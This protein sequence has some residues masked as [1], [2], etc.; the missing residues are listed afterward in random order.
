MQKKDENEII[1]NCGGDI[2][3]DNNRK[4]KYYE[5]NLWPRWVFTEKVSDFLKKDFFIPFYPYKKVNKIQY[6]NNYLFF[7]HMDPKNCFKKIQS[8][9]DQADI[10]CFNMEFP[11]SD[12]PVFYDCIWCK[13]EILKILKWA[14]I[15]FVNIANNHIFDLWLKWFKDTMENLNY[16][17]ISFFWGNNNRDLSHS[18][19][20]FEKDWTKIW[21]L[22]YFQNTRYNINLMCST[23]NKPWINPICEDEIIEDIKNAKNKSWCDLVFVSLHWDIENH[24]RVHKKFKNLCKIIIDSWADWVFWHHSHVPKV[25]EFYNWRPIFYSF[26]NFVFW[27]YYKTFW[28]N[29]ICAQIKIQRN[30]IINIDIY[31]ITWQGEQLFCP[32]IIKK[33]ESKSFII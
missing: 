21:F 26:W 22:W 31:E 8:F 30:K 32:S 27:Q 24:K 25:Y 17:N 11:V 28:K 33:I 4:I 23:D 9:L 20:I 18:P 15:N 6:N 16:Y 13:P 12:E 10:N 1:I 3:L 5:D 2:C 14:N 19:A 7:E 29:N